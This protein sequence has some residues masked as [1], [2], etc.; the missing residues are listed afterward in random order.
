MG[1]EEGGERKKAGGGGACTPYTRD[2][3]YS[4]KSIECNLPVINVIDLPPRDYTTR[5]PVIVQRRRHRGH[6]FTRENT[7]DRN[8]TQQ[9]RRS[10][11]IRSDDSLPSRSRLP[12]NNTTLSPLL[13][14]PRRSRCV[15]RLDSLPFLAW[16]MLMGRVK[17]F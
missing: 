12:N 9:T 4:Q 10:M 8:Y 17:Y 15:F 1:G 2:F 11:L 7:V 13:P 14:L 16:T 5:S 6:I 3:K